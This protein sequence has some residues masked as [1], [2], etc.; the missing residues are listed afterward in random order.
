MAADRQEQ[1]TVDRIDQAKKKVRENAELAF[2]DAE[3]EAAE[4]M[5]ANKIVA[6]RKLEKSR[7]E[8]AV[9][10]VQ[11]KNDATNALQ[12]AYNEATA[13]MEDAEHEIVQKR[14]SK[15]A[16]VVQKRDAIVSKAKAKLDK[17]L[18]QIEALRKAQIPAGAGDDSQEPVNRMDGLV[19]LLQIDPDTAESEAVSISPEM[20]AEE[21]S[22]KNQE[23]TDADKEAADRWIGQFER[24]RDQA[25]QAQQLS[26]VQ[27]QEG[28]ETAVI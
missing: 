17:K 4:S 10:V 16:A 21:I 27:A 6:Q 12:A 14:D 13:Q 19:T 2:K 1:Q 25:L 3:V 20:S 9:N 5:S 23:L 8:A 24:D 28:D 18:E 22:R 15:L 11:E 26:S 7:A